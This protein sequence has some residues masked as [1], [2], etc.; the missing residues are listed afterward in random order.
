MRLGGYISKIKDRTLASKIYQ[1]DETLER[2]RHRYE[3][4]EKYVDI[5]EK[6]GGVFSGFAKVK[7]EN[8]GLRVP[9]IFEI[10]SNKFFISCQFHPEFLSRPF[11]A[12][13]LFKTLIQA[14]IEN[15]FGK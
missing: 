1:D 10:P 8:K 6:N 4:N 15:K 9:E 7:G 5:V 14:G 12:H 3:I 13:P 11:K 2:H